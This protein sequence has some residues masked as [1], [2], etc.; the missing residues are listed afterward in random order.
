VT[1]ATEHTS[2]RTF[3][4]LAEFSA[5]QG[6]VLGY[7]DW[8]EVTQDAVNAFADVTGDRQ[9]IH[10]DTE[11]AASGPFGATIAHGYLTVALLPVLMTE[12][13]RVDNLTMVINYGMN[14]LRFPAPVPT[15]SKIRV[16]ATLTE[17][18]HTP[19]GSLASIRL[20]VEIEGQKRAAC[21]ADALSLFVG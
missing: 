11:R 1:A 3:A 17:I 13:F 12:A 9:W 19:L 7:S 8:H 2:A 4:N 10:V 20:R 5:A 18:R 15:G 6:E 16:L 14:R 21:V